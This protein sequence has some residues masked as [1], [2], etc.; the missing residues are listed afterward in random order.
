MDLPHPARGQI[1]APSLQAHDHH[2]MGSAQHITPYK[3]IG[4]KQWDLEIVDEKFAVGKRG[5]KT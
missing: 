4:S 1:W 5:W 3:F 2:M